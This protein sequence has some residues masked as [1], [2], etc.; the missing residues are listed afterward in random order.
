[1]NL[2]NLGVQEMNAQ[3]AMNI[4]GGGKVGYLGYHWGNYDNELMYA[5]EAV[6]NGGVLVA[7]GGIGLWNLFQ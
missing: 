2:E 6:W 1:M 5:A 7:N 3:E 4:E